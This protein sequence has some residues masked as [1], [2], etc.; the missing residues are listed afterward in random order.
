M[1]R[2]HTQVDTLDMTCLAMNVLYAI[3]NV[4]DRLICYH[5]SSIGG[6]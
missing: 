3:L 6:E 2:Y 5:D 4:P 1:Y